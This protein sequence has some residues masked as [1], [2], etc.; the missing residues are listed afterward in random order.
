M[1]EN[2]DRQTDARQTDDRYA[3]RSF[4]GFLEQVEDG[5]LHHDLTEAYREIVRE[6]SDQAE[7]VG[8]KATGKITVALDL[9][10][11]GGVVE[12]KGEIKLKR[13]E[14]P[15]GRSIFWTTQDDY[16]TRQNPRQGK[17]FKDVKAAEAEAAREA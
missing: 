1:S 15:R 3:L 14:K 7:M 2:D 4:A 8:G 12:C 10:C 6:M 13:P 16:L 11:E 9:K 17:L 5:Q